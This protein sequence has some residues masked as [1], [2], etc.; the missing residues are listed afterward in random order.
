VNRNWERIILLGACLFFVDRSFCDTYGEKLNA[1][2]V[3]PKQIELLLA[4]QQHPSIEGVDHLVKWLREK[5]VPSNKIAHV[6]PVYLDL[7]GTHIEENI[8]K[9]IEP[10]IDWLKKF[11]VTEEGILRILSTHPSF[12]HYE[13]EED[14]TFGEKLDWLRSLG[15]SETRLASILSRGPQIASYSLEKK[16][17]PVW[18]VLHEKFGLTLID[19]EK[20]PM[21]L[22]VD[23][24]RVKSIVEWA[25]VRGIALNSL[26]IEKR[27]R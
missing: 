23:L 4:H 8:K 7:L 6:L 1:L 12:F 16:L 9:K 11:N 15:A 24:E 25:E 13:L 19:I 5:K 10:K 3:D 21:L 20:S 17:K 27:R 22:G 26:P 18:N 2:G 14:S